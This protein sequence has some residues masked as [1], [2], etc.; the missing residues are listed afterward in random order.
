MTR[1]M[2]LTAPGGLDALAMATLPPPGD[3]GPGEIAVRLRASSLNYHDLLVALGAIRAADGRVPMSDGAGEVTAVGDGVTEFAVGDAV[4]STFFPDWL[5]GDA[6]G[7]AAG[8]FARVPGDGIDGYAREAVV[9]AATAFTHAPRG[10]SHAESAT[11]TCAGLT[12]WRALVVEGGLKAG[13]TVLV[14]GGGG[15][16]VFALQ[17]AKAMGATVIATSSSASRLERLRDLGADHVID[18]RATPD[19]GAVARGLSG[20]GVDHVVEVGGAGTLAQSLQAVRI[21]GHVAIIG[22]LSGMEA[23]IPTPLV[24]GKQVRLQGLAVGSRR[25]QRDMIRAIDATGLRPVIDRSFP[26]E[27]LADAFALQQTGA[28]FGK[29]GLEIDG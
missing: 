21:G 3:P 25:H 24:L 11:L 20:G 18:Y 9:A 5:D 27:R 7:M 13:D 19:W 8:G 2:R 17:F 23:A 12:A 28:H 26:L 14:Q 6:G 15:V 10:W 1:A 22:V 29:I 16:S 4:V